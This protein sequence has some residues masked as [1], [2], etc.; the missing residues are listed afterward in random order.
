MME[1]EDKMAISGKT[2]PSEGY[3]LGSVVVKKADGGEVLYRGHG[4]TSLESGNCFFSPAVNSIPLNHW[5]AELLERELNAVLWG[6]LFDYVTRYTIKPGVLYKI[7]DV[8]NDAYSGIEAGVRFHQ[9]AT[10][11]PSG[12]FKQ[13]SF[14]W[15][16]STP[17]ERFPADDFVNRHEAYRMKPGR[18]ARFPALREMARSI[19][20][21]G[22]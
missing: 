15:E 5:T 14:F 21:K 19:A 6:N 4:G 20:Y 12:I 1:N 10:F 7:G 17:L 13:I 3:V 11:T 18:L 8:A 22:H 2:G 16:R 9:M